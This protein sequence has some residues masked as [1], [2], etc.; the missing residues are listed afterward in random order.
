MLRRY[1]KL[2]YRTDRPSDL[3]K[4]DPARLDAVQRFYLKHDII[5]KAVPIA[6]LY[7]NEFVD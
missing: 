3:G 6:D 1:A 5:P 2:V 4:F 7:T